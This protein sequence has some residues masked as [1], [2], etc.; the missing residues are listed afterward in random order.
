MLVY[1]VTS[2]AR[3][4]FPEGLFIS[5]TQ[6]NNH[7]LCPCL[8]SAA[9]SLMR[10]AIVATFQRV[11]FSFSSSLASYNQKYSNI[12][13]K[14]ILIDLRLIP[15]SLNHVFFLYTVPLNP[16]YSSSGPLYLLYLWFSK[17]TV[18]LFQVYLW[19]SVVIVFLVL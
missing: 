8:G 17:P 11:G 12:L 19:S 4:V 16:T 10:F 1:F 15:V 3:M 9:Q 13:S 14:P 18:P 6:D 7:S 5:I 2:R